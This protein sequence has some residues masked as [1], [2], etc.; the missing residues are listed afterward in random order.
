[1]AI[2]IPAPRTTIP[3][4][5]QFPFNTSVVQVEKFISN[6]QNARRSSLI[7]R[8]EEYFKCAGLVT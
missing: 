1:M 4:F 8:F 7:S 2:A 6:V 3:T 5:H